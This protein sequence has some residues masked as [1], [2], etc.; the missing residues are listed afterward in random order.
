[1]ATAKA[2]PINQLNSSYPQNNDNIVNDILKEIDQT[3]T[4][5]DETRDEMT[6][7]QAQYQMDPSIQPQQQYSQEDQN[8]P[9]MQAQMMQ[10]Q[11]DMP[12]DQMYEQQIDPRLL[13]NQYQMDNIPQQTFT[14]KLIEELKNPVIVSIL[15]VIFSFKQFDQSVIKF[16][17]KA[18]GSTGD[19]TPIG[20]CIK[21]LIVGTV[22][23]LVKKFM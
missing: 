14:E 10:Q 19:L 4:N 7:R 6:A 9:G 20:L 2:T 13:Q 8:N 12:P 21:G 1:M 5:Q 3:N 23:Y 22:F 18:L 17:P 15:F 16:I 11:Q